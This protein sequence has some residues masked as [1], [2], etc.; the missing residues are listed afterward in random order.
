MTKVF[1]FGTFDGLHP[2]HEAFLSQA[3][4]HGDEVVVCVAQDSV[5]ELLKKHSP[6][7]L[8]QAR[9]KALKDLPEV[10]DAIA[11]DLELGSYAGFRVARPDIVAFGYDQAELEADFKRFQ[12]ATG[13]ET[14]TIVLK[15]YQPDTYKSSLLRG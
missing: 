1:V 15:P 14:P 11:G 3:R 9:I 13:D 6:Q 10:S 2:G 7:Y 5:V 8:L 12:Q 4:T